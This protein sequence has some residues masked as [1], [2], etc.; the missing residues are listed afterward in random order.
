MHVYIHVYKCIY[1]SIY[2]FISRHVYMYRYILIL[3]SFNSCWIYN[4]RYFYNA[5]FNAI[6]WKPHVRPVGPRV[7][8]W[9]ENPVRVASWRI[10]TPCA[11]PAWEGM[12]TSVPPWEFLLEISCNLAISFYN[13]FRKVMANR[14]KMLVLWLRHWYF[15]LPG[16]WSHD[17]TIHTCG[18]FEIFETWLFS[19]D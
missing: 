13:F 3:Y 18:E 9:L 14:P 10:W 16:F 4:D 6:I 11:A 7:H 2:T 8:R 19:V 17:T 1:T 5:G 12:C 15:I